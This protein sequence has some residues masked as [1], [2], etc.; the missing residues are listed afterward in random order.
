MAFIPQSIGCPMT[1]NTDESREEYR[2]QRVT[3]E[4][5]SNGDFEADFQSLILAL[6]G[7]YEADAIQTFITSLKMRVRKAEAA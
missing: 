2:L 7:K 5:L 3:D 6:G 4:I 1:V